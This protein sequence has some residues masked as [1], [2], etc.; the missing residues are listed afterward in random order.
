ML[1][2]G[3]PLPKGELRTFPIIFKPKSPDND[4]YVLHCTATLIGPRVL[5]TAAHC[6][7]NGP[8][9]TIWD[10]N[11]KG[12]EHLFDAQCT[13]H[14]LYQQNINVTADYALCLLGK[15]LK[16]VKPEWVS[17]QPGLL[18][19][20]AL[21]VLTG[22][23]CTDI[24]DQ[25]KPVVDG[26]IV[27]R[28]GGG[29]ITP[30]GYTFNPN[31]G[32]EDFLTLGAIEGDASLCPGDSGGAV[33]LNVDRDGRSVTADVSPAKLSARSVLVGVN[34]GLVSVNDNVSIIAATATV[35]FRDFLSVWLL[36][37]PGIEVCDLE[38]RDEDR[39]ARCRQLD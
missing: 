23:G 12:K 34:S 16:D 13:A 31:P 17:L 8:Q 14:P 2:G 26:D 10:Q 24:K 25:G 3:K 27:P 9:I 4:K 1:R 18:G 22:F 35:D 19:G 33:M 5:L 30:L 36:E 29:R 37:H 39:N 38:F 6:L 15:E 11:A 28:Q 20:E 32:A 21:L 7:D